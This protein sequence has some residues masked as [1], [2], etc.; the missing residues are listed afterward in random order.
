M[1]GLA[2]AIAYLTI[3]RLPG[4]REFDLRRAVVWF[5]VVGLLL[6]AVLAVAWTG[7]VH[8][9]PRPVA[10][11]L[12]TLLWVWLTGGMHLDG[13]ADTSD[14]LLSWRNRENMLEVMRSPQV[15]A[16][17]MATLVSTLL[18]K[19]VALY[20]LPDAKVAAALLCAPLFGRS[21]QVLSTCLLPYAKEDG[22]A[23][24]A[25]ETGRKW[26]RALAALIPLVVCLQL[27]WE[28]AALV[29]VGTFALT[30]TL[31]VRIRRLLGGMTGDT[32]GA[33]TEIVEAAFLIL[34]T[35]TLPAWPWF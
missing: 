26:P 11:F 8:V 35:A 24:T 18:A 28:S 13:L 33:V 10:V 25:F 29:V 15:G 23:V 2:V 17:G 21:A 20:N 16:V 14:A 27:G 31:L 12:T 4:K 9:T 32:L 34:A 5:P 30:F 3:V 7:L 1:N 19:A 22:V 6:G